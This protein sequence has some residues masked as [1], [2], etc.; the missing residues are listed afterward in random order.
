MAQRQQLV[1]TSVTSYMWYNSCFIINGPIFVG[2]HRENLFGRRSVHVGWY[3]VEMINSPLLHLYNRSKGGVVFF[4]LFSRR[5]NEHLNGFIEAMSRLVI[6]YLF[7]SSIQMNS[8]NNG[9]V[10][11]FTIIFRHWIGFLPSVASMSRMDM[12]W[13]LKKIWNKNEKSKDYCK[14][15][16]KQRLL[17]F[18]TIFRLAIPAFLRFTD[19]TELMWQ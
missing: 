3:G 5:Y 11:S 8:L 10:L 2:S 19:V 15:D 7:V 13:N 6:C 4:T 12:D 17:F 9:P 16:L 1:F 18:K 14:A